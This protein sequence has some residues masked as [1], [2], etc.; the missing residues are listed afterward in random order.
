MFQPEVK[1]AMC[2]LTPVRRHL[3]KKVR[4]KEGEN[5]LDS[6]TGQNDAAVSILGVLITVGFVRR[7]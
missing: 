1:S 5:I 4:K 2:D 6:V 7:S 3:R